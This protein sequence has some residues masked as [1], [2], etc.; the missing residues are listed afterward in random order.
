MIDEDPQL[1]TAEV[2]HRIMLTY[3]DVQVNELGEEYC[4]CWYR[5]FGQGI[6][7]NEHQNSFE[8]H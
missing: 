8:C 4:N 1:F 6:N 5:L 7:Y 3:R 2:I